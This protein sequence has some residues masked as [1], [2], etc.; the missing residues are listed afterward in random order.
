MNSHAKWNKILMYRWVAYFR[1]MQS[2]LAGPGCK[3][4]AHHSDRC[5][6]CDL[7]ERG[8][9]VRITYVICEDFEELSRWVLWR[10]VGTSFHICGR[11]FGNQTLYRWVRQSAL[12]PQTKQPKFILCICYMIFS[13]MSIN[14]PGNTSLFAPYLNPQDTMADSGNFQTNQY[15]ASE[16]NVTTIGTTH[17]K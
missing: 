9:P 4:C 13:T 3:A 1:W 7:V 17:A 15:K 14:V 5:K 2:G 6:S 8:T 11:H 16:N 12:V 10:T